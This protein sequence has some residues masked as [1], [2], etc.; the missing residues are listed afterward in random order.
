[1]TDHIAYTQSSEACGC[2]L[3]QGWGTI[4][5]KSTTDVLQDVR[6]VWNGYRSSYDP[7]DPVV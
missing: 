6:R 4:Y 5:Y 2:V 7:C 3:A 1:M